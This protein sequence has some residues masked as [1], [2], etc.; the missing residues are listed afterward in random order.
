MT[1]TTFARLTATAAA[2]AVIA[3]LL[4]ASH[5]TWSA[6]IVSGEKAL[7]AAAARPGDVARIELE[8][9]GDKLALARGKDDAWTVVQRNGYPVRA[10]KVRSLLL[11]LAE[12]RLVETRTRIP[13]KHKLLELEDTSAKDAKSRLV[14]LLDKDGKAIG[15]MILGKSLADAFGSGKGGIYVRRPGEAQTWLADRSPEVAILPRDWIERSLLQLDATRN[16]ELTIEQPDGQPP[17]VVKGKVKDGKPD[18]FELGEPIPEGKRFKGSENADGI[19]RSFAILDLDDV[20]KQVAPAAGAAVRKATLLTTDG[21]TLT[22][23]IVKE[24]D[25]TWLAITPSGSAEAVKDEVAKL[26]KRLGGWQFKLSTGAAENLLKTR[27]EL[28]EEVPKPDGN[29]KPFSP[30]APRR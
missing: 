3:G 22:Y 23:E 17:L 18:G 10:D 1:P 25:A 12:M 8:Q 2:S 21:M 26:T 27:A 7:P 9:G 14:R 4:Y 15:E 16:K 20:R 13:D 28:F 19:A 24:K 11:A 5:N 30:M 29:E 6:G